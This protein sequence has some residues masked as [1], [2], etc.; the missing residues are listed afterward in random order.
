MD[1][2]EPKDENHAFKRE[3][4]EVERWDPPLQGLLIERGMQKAELPGVPLS[5]IKH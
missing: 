2:F 4:F 1:Y 3:L 5:V